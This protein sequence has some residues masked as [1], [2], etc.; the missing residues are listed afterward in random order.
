MTARQQREV[1]MLQMM[2]SLDA[3]TSFVSPRGRAP[4]ALPGGPA[5]RRM[6]RSASRRQLHRLLLETLDRLFETE[7][8][9]DC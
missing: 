9:T 2:L 8:D 6:I 1:R 3:A 4:A 5:T 7:V